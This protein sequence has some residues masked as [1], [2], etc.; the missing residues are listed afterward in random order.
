MLVF[1]NF[2]VIT[3]SLVPIFVSLFILLILLRFGELASELFTDSCDVLISL[4]MVPLNAFV[5][6]SVADRAEVAWM[7]VS[8]L[9]VISSFLKALVPGAMTKSEHMG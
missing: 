9:Q 6:L 4:D 1:S 5:K 2:Q 3:S 7:S 8:L